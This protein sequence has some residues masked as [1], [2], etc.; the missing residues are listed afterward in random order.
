MGYFNK[1]ESAHSCPSNYLAMADYYFR[2][3]QWRLCYTS[4]QY[5]FTLERN[6]PD[7]LPGDWGDDPRLRT[8][9]PH[10]FA[11]TAAFHLWDFEASYG[12]AV[13]AVRRAPNDL[14]LRNHLAKVRAKITT[15]STVSSR[16]PSTIIVPMRLPSEEV[17]ES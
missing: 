5:A 13:E 16:T 2:T 15:G 4:I 3:K 17:A 10:E 12:H 7:R 1:A 9:L 8:S 6:N 11:S 14:R